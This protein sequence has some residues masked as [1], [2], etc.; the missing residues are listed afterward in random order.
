MVKVVSRM[1]IAAAVT[2]AAT[3]FTVVAASP[4]RAD[5]SDCLSYLEGAGYPISPPRR[6][7]CW[8]GSTSAA[9]SWFLCWDGLV[10]T[11]IPSRVAAMACDRAK[12]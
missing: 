10:D 7:A 8:T 12:R 11:R 2:A 6:D 9:G 5:Y 4:A 1:A 3:G